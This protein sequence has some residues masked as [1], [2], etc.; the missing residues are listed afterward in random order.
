MA[1]QP[2][3]NLL[4]DRGPV[5]RFPQ[6]REPVLDVFSPRRDRELQHRAPVSPIGGQTQAPAGARLF[7]LRPEKAHQ[8]F[9]ADRVE[10]VGHVGIPTGPGREA[11]KELHDLRQGRRVELGLHPPAAGLGRL[12]EQRHQNGQQSAGGHPVGEQAARELGYQLREYQAVLEPHPGPEGNADDQAVPV[13]DP[14]LDQNLD[15][16]REQD[17]HQNDEIAGDGRAGYRQDD[18]ERLGEEGE[19]DE[20]RAGGDPHA[21]RRDAGELGQRRAQR[22][23]VV[24]HRS[25]ETAQEIAE[26]VDVH[27]ALH[28]AE[29]DRPRAAPGHALDGDAAADRAQADDQRYQQE[30]GNQRPEIRPEP[31]I[32][33]RPGDARQPDPRRAG[34]PID[35]VEPE[36]SADRR[37][38]DHADAGRPETQRAG[39]PQRG[40]DDDQHGDAGGER[41]DAGRGPFRHVVEHPEED[42]HDGNRQEHDQRGRNAPAEDPPEERDPRR[43][44][45]LEDG[46]YHDQG[47]EQRRAAFLDRI[48]AEPDEGGGTAH[49][50]RLAGADPPVTHG[51]QSRRRAANR[52]RRGYGPE[53]VGLVR[54]GGAHDD[55]G[56]QYR[57]GDDE[58]R[59]LQAEPHAEGERYPLV[60]LVPEALV[61]GVSAHAEGSAPRAPR[62]RYGT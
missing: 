47:G 4:L 54:A 2:E 49:H 26:S 18:G 5:V 11:A 50:Q 36:E 60:G 59:E 24:R 45:E 29:I 12:Q 17:R 42:R 58:R 55:R 32:E 28:R 21:P 1:Q 40:A 13:I 48:D 22:V 57:E 51:L 62:I 43:K 9:L 3:R 6:Q 19:D 37:A 25:G 44:D 27:P 15:S 14:L 35:V 8:G 56:D 41:R 39:A 46:G 34:D 33:T 10:A 23:G 16:D 31:E 20:D 30:R 7:L 61:R 52:D 53:Q 38:G